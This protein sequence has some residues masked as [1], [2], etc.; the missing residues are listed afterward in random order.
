MA[1]LRTLSLN[2][3]QHLL[4]AALPLLTEGTVDAIEWSFDALDRLPELPDW[5]AE[6]L[7]T[8]AKAGRLVGHGIFYSVC[9]AQ[10]TKDQADWL[11]RLSEWQRRFP[12]DHV[13]EHFGFMTGRDFHR[14]AP[15]SPPLSAATLAV[16]RD[17]L[18]RLQGACERPV[19]LEN[20]ALAYRADDVRR[21]GVFLEQLL[22]PING[23][24]L[25]DAHNLYCQAHNFGIDPIILCQAYPLSRVR[26]IHLSGGSWE[27]HPLAPEK[28]VRR[29]THDD[30]VPKEV[31]QLA[32]YLLANCPNLKY[33]TL[34]QLSPALKTKEQRVGFS[35]D[36]RQMTKLASE[37]TALGVVANFS[38]PS[39]G[40]PLSEP[41]QD[42]G[43]ATQQR[44][45]SD[46]LET[47]PSSAVLRE[48]LISSPLAKSDWQVEK[49]EDHMLDTVWQ[50]AQKWK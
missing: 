27:P 34:E 49:W 24:L 9:A 19:G 17:R 3:D 6:L 30:R 29:D 25:L 8:Y 26:E 5:F 44:I 18:L 1:H 10:W 22:E 48:Q 15:I 41:Y 23:F 28:L 20:L 40:L 37:A 38:P 21:Q 11:H 4:Q 7:G 12:L 32:E 43:L 16:G 13:T 2:L 45:L 31:F 42:L 50:I 47:T 14:G 39:A 46:L 36:F 35:A 33:I